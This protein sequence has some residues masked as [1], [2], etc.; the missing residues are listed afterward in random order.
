MIFIK[1]TTMISRRVHLTPNTFVDP[2]N[3]FGGDPFSQSAQDQGYCQQP[4]G[5]R[6]QNFYPSNIQQP[7]YMQPP[8]QYNQQANPSFYGEQHPQPQFPNTPNNPFS[9]NGNATSPYPPEQQMP[10]GENASYYG[11]PPQ[12]Q[13]GPN[14]EDEKGL[15]STVVGGAAGGYAGHKLG[16][17][18]LGSAAGAILGAVGLNA[19]THQV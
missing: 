15:G 4:G 6:P 3:Q 11:M 19:A 7:G 2:P 13:N 18:L 10:I 5:P 9:Q 14:P 17:G 1:S 12:N 16:G 8:V